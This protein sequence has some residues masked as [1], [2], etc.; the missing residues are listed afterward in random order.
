MIQNRIRLSRRGALASLLLA[1]AVVSAGCAG[2]TNEPLFPNGAHNIAVPI[3]EN[4][5]F[6]RQI[7]FDLTRSVCDVLRQRPGIHVTSEQGAD[8]I[9]KGTIKKLDQKVL[10]LGHSESVKESSATTEVDCEILDARTGKKL[11]AFRAKESVPFVLASGEGLQTAQQAT[12]YDL[13]RKIVEELE[14]DW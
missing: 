7:E 14:A 13:A 4:E 6:F 8:I 12:Y 11:K 3:F 5:T 2:Y 10:S 9:L 1:G